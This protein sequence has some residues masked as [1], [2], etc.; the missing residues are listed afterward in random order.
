MD[1][2]DQARKHPNP[3]PIPNLNP[4]PKP[5]P[6]PYPYPYPNRRP[7]PGPNNN[8][9][10]NPNPDPNHSPSPNQEV[11]NK[12]LLVLEAWL[13]DEAEGGGAAQMRAVVQALRA[14][15][16]VSVLALDGGGTSVKSRL[17]LMPQLLETTWAAPPQPSAQPT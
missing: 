2:N 3:N 10:T 6:Y 5:N 15:A 14:Y 17:L 1:E 9:K 13:A 11:I 8:P 4:N 12:E 7:N 16:G